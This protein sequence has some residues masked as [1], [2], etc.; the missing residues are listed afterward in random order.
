[1]RNL[2][3]RDP[4]LLTTR[5]VASMLGVHADTVRRYWKQEGLPMVRLPGSEKKAGLVRFDR[6][7][8]EAWIVARKNTEEPVEVEP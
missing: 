2:S 3:I 7:A 5:Q 1:M 8:V 4:N 6:A